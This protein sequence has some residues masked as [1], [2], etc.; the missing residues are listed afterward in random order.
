MSNIE[1]IRKILHTLPIFYKSTQRL[2]HLLIRN[3]KDVDIKI[4]FLKEI[5][6]FFLFSCVLLCNM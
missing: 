4:M 5:F 1:Y 3:E 6:A 2:N